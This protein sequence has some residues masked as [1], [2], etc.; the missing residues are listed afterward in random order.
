MV[1]SCV[2]AR[3]GVLRLERRRRRLRRMNEYYILYRCYALDGERTMKKE[4]IILTRIISCCALC[5]NMPPT[6]FAR[7]GLAIN[8]DWSR[9]VRIEADPFPFRVDRLTVRLADSTFA[10]VDLNTAAIVEMVRPVADHS[11]FADEAGEVSLHTWA[12]GADGFPSLTNPRVRW[13]RPPLVLEDINDPL[14]L[15]LHDLRE[16]RKVFFASSPDEAERFARKRQ[17]HFASHRFTL[18]KRSRDNSGFIALLATK[19]TNWNTMGNAADIEA[20]LNRFGVVNG[21][22]EERAKARAAAG[23][24]H[25]V[26]DVDAYYAIRQLQTGAE[27]EEWLEHKMQEICVWRTTVGVAFEWARARANVTR[28]EASGTWVEPRHVG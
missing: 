27:A 1:V 23:T 13:G 22:L 20:D 19:A 12:L 21:T 7:I 2:V 10:Q 16:T 8:G 3:E 28:N 15:M 5:S 17:R 18:R 9:V 25:I 6:M 4:T 26:Y 14:L 11:N 24:C